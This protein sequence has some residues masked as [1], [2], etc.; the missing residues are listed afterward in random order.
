MDYSPWGHKE[1]DIT[2]II[3]HAHSPTLWTQ[4]PSVRE[5]QCLTPENRTG[6]RK[7]WDLNPGMSGPFFFIPTTTGHDPLAQNQN[8]WIPS[9]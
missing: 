9:V 4:K 6:N 7:S 2:E 5:L 1:S 8:R 3:G